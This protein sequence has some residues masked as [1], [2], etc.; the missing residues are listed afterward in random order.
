MNA[1]VGIGIYDIRDAH[2]LTQAPRQT[3]R[4][5]LTGY[6]SSTGVHHPPMWDP[7]IEQSDAVALSFR[8]LLELR[9]IYAFRKRKVSA[10]LLRKAVSRASEI[11]GA[12]HPFSSARFRTDGASI[13][14]Q[15]DREQGEPELVNIFTNQREMKTIIEQSL[16]DVEYDGLTP[17]V[18]RPMGRASGVVLDPSRSFGQPIEEDTAIPTAT[19]AAA[20]KA[21]GS[22]A[23]AAALYEVPRHAVSRA[24]KFEEWLSKAA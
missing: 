12:D 4:R 23:R 10:Q 11:I 18:W 20:A 6:T 16:R 14:L 22:V 7:D 24:V 9:A 5:W 3:I 21:E 19:L 1:L 13:L 15:L 17:N 2:R 8:D